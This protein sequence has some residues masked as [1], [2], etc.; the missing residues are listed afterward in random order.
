MPLAE[1]HLG[2]R[3]DAEFYSKENIEIERS[4]RDHD[5][6]PLSDFCTMAASAF[7]PAATHLYESGDVPFARCV[8]CVNY[9]VISTIQDAEFERLPRWFIDQCGQIST[10]RRGE[11]IL[12]KVGSPCFASV[13]H[14][15][16]EI[17]L[18]RTVM[19]LVQI[20]GINPYYLTAF[21]RCRYGFNQL[22]RQR[23]QTIQYQLTLDRV[24]EILVFVPS[25]KFQAAIEKLMLGNIAKLQQA[26]HHQTQSEQT[27]LQALGLQ[28]WEPPEPLTYTRRA[29][30]ALA[31][32]RIDSEYFRPQFAALLIKM[33]EHGKILRL[34]D[35]VRFCERGRQPQYAEEGLPVINSRHVRANKVVLD[36]DNRFATE[37]AAQHN[38]DE[39][40]RYTIK[41]GDLLING[42]GVG[43][44]G[45]CAPYLREDKALP[46]NHVTI[47]RMKPEMGLDPIFLSVQLNSIIGQMQVE[48]YFKGSSGQIELYP[49]EIKEFRIWL[50]PP[51]VQQQ[52]KSHVEQAHQTRQEAQELL[53]KAKRAV[54]LAIE[55]SETAAMKYL[56]EN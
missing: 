46:D 6:R 52:I 17:A 27:L 50:A 15:Y 7:Y 39:E 55:E 18:S 5:A 47:L 21:L 29:S 19:G 26:D 3:A 25:T 24:R 4:L 10:A 42:T 33:E 28:G 34:G 14:D 45:R 13:I 23:E 51:K 31:A 2:D 22:L 49:S 43:T 16:E 8:D 9:P 40:D 53:T 35:C 1:I 56:K 48:Q 37:N 41:Q 32:N 36:H 38:L 30:E 20:K 44:I 11:I 54:E 12:S